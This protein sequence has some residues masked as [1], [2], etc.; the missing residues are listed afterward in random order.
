MGSEIRGALAAQTV[1]LVQLGDADPVALVVRLDPAS[2]SSV[3]ALRDLPVGLATKVALDTIA[4]VEQEDVQGRITRIDSAPSA[5]IAAEFTSGDTGATSFAVQAVIDQLRADGAIPPAADVT[6]GGVTAQ[7]SAAFGGL[8]TAMGVAI[9]LVHLMMVL[10]FNSLVTPFIILFSLPLATI[11]AFPALLLTGRPIGL[12]ALI[13]FLML[14][15]IVV[16]NAIVLFDLV[17]R[18]RADGHSTCDAL[19]EGG[20]TRIRPS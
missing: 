15:G 2:L 5:T 4:D 8:F 12:S 9:V 19:I 18:L 20:R 16:T 6:L 13:G 3:E 10:A 17:E 7:Q 14:I 11:G 1:G